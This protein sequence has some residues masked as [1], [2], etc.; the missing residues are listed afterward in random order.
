MSTNYVEYRKTCVRGHDDTN[1]LIKSQR[2]M[3]S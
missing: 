3:F 2:K 1:Y